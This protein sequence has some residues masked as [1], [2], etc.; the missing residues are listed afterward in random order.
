MSFESP[1]H[2]KPFDQ[3]FEEEY[4]KREIVALEHGQTKVLDIRPEHS[5]SERPLLIASGYGS[6]S[7]TGV[8]A[9]IAE[10][11]RLGR[12][13]MM[14]EAPHG[15]PHTITD[16]RAAEMPETFKR[17]IAALIPTLEKKHI[18][19]VDAIGQSAGCIRIIMA[20]YL[21]PEK[22]KN[23]VLVDPGG[24]IGEDTPAR[25]TF[26]FI[27]DAIATGFK[28]A[29][30]ASSL[31][32]VEREQRKETPPEFMHYVLEDRKT[33]MREVKDLA[34]AEIH[35][36]LRSVKDHGIGISI[37]HGVD[38]A[39]F[40]M[41]RINPDPEKNPDPKKSILLSSED[42]DGFYSVRGGHAELSINPEQYTQA[43]ERALSALEEKQERSNASM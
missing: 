28:V 35:G 15:L 40:P 32:N 27:K 39:V 34:R 19:K 14:I 9:N 8:K 24:M 21:Y 42:L 25:L 37:I 33:T 18:D 3:W 26:R 12:R 7:P 43:A 36:L 20:A 23:I 2:Q 10:L 16:E 30:R 1:E 5:K 22:F 38:D 17:E 41:E 6:G 31:S 29:K 13:T 11:V 4:Q